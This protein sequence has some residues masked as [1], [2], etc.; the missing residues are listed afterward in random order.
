M[1][2]LELIAFADEL[3]KMAATSGPMAPQVP[4]P[5]MPQVSLAFS[6]GKRF[7]G[8]PKVKIPTPATLNRNKQ[9]RKNT[10]I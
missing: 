3:R 5:G 6:T 2:S 10:N 8:L 1:K 9:Q 4:T 7:A